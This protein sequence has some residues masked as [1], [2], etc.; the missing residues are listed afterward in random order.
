M[1]LMKEQRVKV[2]QLYYQ[3]NKNGTKASCLLSAEFTIQQVQSWNN[4]S[5]IRKFERTGN[6][7]DALRS[8]RPV[9]EISL[10]KSNEI[11][12]SLLSM[13]E[14]L[15]KRL[16]SELGISERIVHRLLKKLKRRPDIP[17]MEMQIDRILKNFSE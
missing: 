17:R 7:G 11:K 3:N 2:V 15:S 14:K 5:L 10:E 12:E 8:G 4:T 1:R 6:I 13:P 9:S 16:S